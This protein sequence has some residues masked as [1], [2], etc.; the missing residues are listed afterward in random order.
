MD[1][2]II[3]NYIYIYLLVGALSLWS[4]IHNYICAPKFIKFIAFATRYYR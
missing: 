2:M 1:S 3:P 4:Q